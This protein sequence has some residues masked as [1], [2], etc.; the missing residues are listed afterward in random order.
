V[1][2]ASKFENP[3]KIGDKMS[4]RVSATSSENDAECTNGG[5]KIAS[6]DGARKYI[7]VPDTHTKEKKNVKT[8]SR[9]SRA[10]SRL[11][12]NFS[13]KNGMSTERETMDATV[14][15]N[16]SGILKAE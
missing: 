9:N 12:S 10:S 8:V 3:R 14:T 13:S 11:A 7:I 15:N 6:I 5:N 4:I 1:T 16:I 2:L